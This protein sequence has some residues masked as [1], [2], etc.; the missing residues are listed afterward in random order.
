MPCSAMMRS[1]EAM[2]DWKASKR[3]LRSRIGSKKR[4]MYST[5]ATSTPAADLLTQNGRAAHPDGQGHGDR[6]QKIDRGKEAGG[7]AY[8]FQIDIQVVLVDLVAEV[9]M[10]VVF[11]RE[12]LDDAHGIDIFC[13]DR[14]DPGDGG[15]GDPVVVAGLFSEEDRDQRSSPESQKK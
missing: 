14:I 1:P 2:V 10:I 5:N 9:G 12:G 3:L 4:L 8:G 6:P 7:E 11:A 15:A 13:Q